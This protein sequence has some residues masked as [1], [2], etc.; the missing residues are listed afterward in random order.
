ME[1][2]G[3]YKISGGTNPEIWDSKPGAYGHNCQNCGQKG[4]SL[5][6]HL[7][8][9]GFAFGQDFPVKYEQMMLCSECRDFLQQKEGYVKKIALVI[10]IIVLGMIGL[11]FVLI[12][13]SIIF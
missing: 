3:Y 9:K 12:F 1:G 11:N 5:E 2:S 8:R 13:G 10:L 6:Q 7:V 4:V